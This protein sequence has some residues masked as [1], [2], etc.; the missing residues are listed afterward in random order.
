MQTHSFSLKLDQGVSLEAL[1][2]LLPLDALLV[3]FNYDAVDNSCQLTL[4]QPIK[5][6]AIDACD[7][8]PIFDRANYYF[9]TIAEQYSVGALLAITHLLEAQGLA[10]AC[11]STNNTQALP[12]TAL[13][14]SL[15]GELTHQ[16]AF[17]EA[18]LKLSEQF[19]VDGFL[20]THQQYHTA[21]KLACFDMDST[22]IQCEVIDELAKAYGIGEQVSA[23]TERAMRG[24]L[25]FKQSFAERLSLLEGLSENVLEDIAA[26]LPLTKGVETLMAYCRNQGIKTAIFSGGFTYFAQHLKKHLGFDYIQ[27]NT[28]DIVD[29][30]VTGMV[31]GHVV[32]AEKKADLLSEIAEKEQLTIDQ[33]IAVGDGANDLLML[34]KAGMGVAFWAKP[35]VKKKAQFS[36]SHA[37]LDALI[38][39]IK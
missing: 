21:W 36:L 27:A 30:K 9:T 39:C 32:D 22:L 17:H 11:I 38:Y 13:V 24:E 29:G 19:P 7:V 6:K 23:I 20:Q 25:D 37:G 26:N 5:Q 18:Q 8:M 3:A 4:N 28:L 2:T 14:F 33:V 15:S 16:A 10:I 35:I 34:D 1:K 31:Q 12:Y